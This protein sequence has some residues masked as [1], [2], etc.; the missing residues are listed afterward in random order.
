MGILLRNR[1]TRVSLEATAPGMLPPWAPACPNTF[2]L[3]WMFLTDTARLRL[4]HLWA[5]R[6]PDDPHRMALLTATLEQLLALPNIPDLETATAVR[7]AMFFT[8]W[9]YLRLSNR[10]RA[11]HW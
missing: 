9:N 3:D 7:Q 11:V 8:V 5:F 2:F 10:E 4:R 6:H 1:A